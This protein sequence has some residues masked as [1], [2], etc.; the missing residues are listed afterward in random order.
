MVL[1]T[2]LL[3]NPE[4]VCLQR[5]PPCIH[6]GKSPAP[7]LHLSLGAPCHLLLS[8][9]LRFAPASCG[10]PACGAG[11]REAPW[12]E[13][14]LASC[15]VL[16]APCLANPRGIAVPFGSFPQEGGRFCN[17]I[18]NVSISAQV[19]ST[20]L[21]QWK[22]PSL[23]SRVGNFFRHNKSEEKAKNTGDQ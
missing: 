15:L 13:L 2:G 5:H 12:E 17:I 22:T 3:V 8:K 20:L 6:H 10:C 11:H 1:A 4:G 14:V 19:L 16:V 7:T 18:I 21:E 9:V 23:L